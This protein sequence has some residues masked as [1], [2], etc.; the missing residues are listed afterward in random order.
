MAQQDQQ[1]AY[2]QPAQPREFQP[3]NQG[4]LLLLNTSCKFLD[5]WHC[6]YKVLERVSP[7]NYCLQ[8]PSKY[9]DTQLYHINLLT[10]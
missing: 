3:G 6:P 2:N 7:V 4:L 1:R 10:K 5:C 9:A 8:Q